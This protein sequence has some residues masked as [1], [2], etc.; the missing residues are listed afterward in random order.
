MAPDK[1]DATIRKVGKE[2][3]IFSKTGKNLGC[4]PTREAAEKRL[5]QIERF[6]KEKAG[7]HH[8]KINSPYGAIYNM[9]KL[10]KLAN[11]NEGPPESSEG[12]V[13]GLISELVLDQRDHFPVTKQDQAVSSA[14]RVLKIETAPDWFSGSV[15]ELQTLVLSSVAAHHPTLRINT[16]VDVKTVY[17]ALAEE[18][19]KDKVKDPN[20]RN[21][22]L[23][24]PVPTPTIDNTDNKNPDDT[25]EAKG[26]F[27]GTLDELRV[28]VKSALEDGQPDMVVAMTQTSATSLVE[29]I[30]KQVDKLKVARKVAERLSSSGLTADEFNK[31]MDYLQEDL[32]RDLLMQG[33]TAK[34]D[35]RVTVLQQV[36]RKRK[37]L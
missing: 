33:V 28:R 35:P 32:L 12:T 25:N 22:K 27:M 34:E 20:A 16:A 3:C 30:D 13:A 19:T 9:G 11:D 36:V 10:N 24:P 26:A 15:E 7:M 5:Q 29:M 6:S 18:L 23:V 31:L 8:N 2:F 4:K 1:A 21:R 37:E 14:N 17:A